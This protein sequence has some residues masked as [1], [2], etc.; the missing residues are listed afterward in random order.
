[1]LQEEPST[2]ERARVIATLSNSIIKAIEGGEL[3]ELIK[4]IE[5]GF[6]ER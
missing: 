5:K 3:D 6:E 4:E 2:V 1:M